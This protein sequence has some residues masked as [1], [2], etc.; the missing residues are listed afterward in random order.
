MLIYDTHRTILMLPEKC[1]TSTLQSRL[2]KLQ[3]LEKF[4]FGINYNSDIDAYI[5][6]HITLKNALKTPEFNARKDYFK[7]CFIRNPYDRVYSWFKWLERKHDNDLAENNIEKWEEA[8]RKDGAAS[9]PSIPVKYKVATRLAKLINETGR[10]FNRFV[11]AAPKQ[12]RRTSTYTHLKKICV[13]DFIGYVETFET[14]FVHLC[15]AIGFEDYN[16]SNKNYLKIQTSAVSNPLDM[17]IE[18]HSYLKHYN[19]KAIG[20]VN[21]RLAD[22]FKLHGFRKFSR[23]SF[24]N[25]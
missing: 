19:R 20:A 16:A 5:T 10:D 21:K 18:E 3:R 2:G 13:M 8:I 11:I 17:T 22:D 9:D 6:K 24:R 15:E 23:W 1:G 25:S 14:D 4:G 12:Y 7:A